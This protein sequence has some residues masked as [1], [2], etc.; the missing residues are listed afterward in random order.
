M[1]QL[2]RYIFGQL[3]FTVL[4]ATTV[5]TCIMWLAQSLRYIDYIANKGVPI[6][7][8]LKMILFLLP[9]LFVIVVPIAI[10]I[11]VLFI[12]NKLITDHE[13]VVM[14]ASGVGYWQLAKPAITMATFFTVILYGF[15]LYFLPLSFTEY[16][17]IVVTLQEETLAN[18][19]QVGQFNS[20]GKYTVYARNQDAQGNYLGILI[21]DGNQSGKETLFMAEKGVL[22]NIKEGGQLLLLNGNRQETDKETGKP[23]VLYFE[24]YI[25][26]AKD[27]TSGQA[28]GVR[29]VRAYERSVFDLL[30]PKEH[31]SPKMRLEFLTAA[32]QR[33]LSPLYALA[34]ALIG[35]CSMILGQFDR[36]GR[37][38]KIIIAC[39]CASILQ[40]STM[41]FL[42]TL[43]Y[44]NVMIPLSY[45]IV[46][47]TIFICLLLLCTGL[48]PIGLL[49][50]R[51]S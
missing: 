6:L 25:I 2:S 45:G 15:T 33:V 49:R 9:N 40:V 20:L 34:F 17:N 13:L 8:F 46:F 41:I 23:S 28:P 24:R 38:G 16:R 29:F 10:L 44:T 22:F 32:H 18:L 37:A 51:R 39:V 30:S 19:I 48:S 47:S 4:A 5:L 35:V 43:N 12:Y 31:L 11:G 1:K 36:K 50:G 21:Y 7:L 3:F 26:E 42:H 14:Q 27:S